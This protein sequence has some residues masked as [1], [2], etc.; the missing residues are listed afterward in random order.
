MTRMLL[1]SGFTL[2]AHLDSSCCGWC[3]WRG[4][5]GAVTGLS[6]ETVTDPAVGRVNTKDLRYLE[7]L[8]MQEAAWLLKMSHF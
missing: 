2:E 5:R 4:S 3:P 8:G 1:S 6:E 7:H